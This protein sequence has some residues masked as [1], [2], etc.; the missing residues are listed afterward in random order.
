MF[1]KNIRE[2]TFL[3]NLKKLLNVQKTSF[4]KKDKRFKN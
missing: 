3:K 2:K 1:K 4:T